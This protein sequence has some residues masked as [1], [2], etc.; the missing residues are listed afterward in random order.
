MTRL[1]LLLVMVG[2]LAACSS[3]QEENDGRGLLVGL[4]MSIGGDTALES[5]E[6]VRSTYEGAYAGMPYT[7]EVVWTRPHRVIF[8][9]EA[10]GFTGQ[11]GVDNGVAWSSFMAPV[12]RL[13]GAARE[14]MM[15]W[16]HHYEVFLVR[17]LLHME[18]LEIARGPTNRT[19]GRVVRHVLLTF[20]D[21]KR[22]DLGIQVEEG[23]STLVM[24]DGDT[25]LPDGRKGRFTMDLSGHEAF[26]G[27]VWPTTVHFR[28]YVGKT[29]IQAKTE[30]VTS[31]QWNPPV[32][33]DTFAMPEMTIHLGVKSVKEAPAVTGLR[34]IHTGSPKTLD[35]TVLSLQRL[36]FDHG[37]IPMGS[38]MVTFHTREIEVV[39]PAEV[40]DG[41][42]PRLP[43]GITVVTRPAM[44][45]AAV[46]CRGPYGT[47]DVKA[48]KALQEWLKEGEYEMVGAP[49]VVF[50]HDPN[51]TVGED[52]V[53][54]VQIPV[55]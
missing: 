8:K 4:L 48:L 36:C 3:Q 7:S 30:T 47:A 31:I 53:A 54:E 45:V 43:K 5:V 41:P 50:L 35:Q 42:G 23:K 10:D 17:P 22:Y 14:N 49:R 1:V 25:V 51:A 29:V 52:Q 26:D 44:K 18:G 38:A 15:E 27:I 11:M 2:L 37:F 28:T 13:R 46:M 24:V 55:M 33:D 16:R 12:A 20:P 6:G 19:G 32:T 40:P 34:T 9:L 39:Y 21:G